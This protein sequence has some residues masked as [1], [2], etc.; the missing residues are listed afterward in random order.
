MVDLTSTVPKAPVLVLGASGQVGRALARRLGDACV[1]LTRREADLAHP[2]TLADILA[3]YGPAIIINAAAYTAVD[4]AEEEP[5]QAHT[6]NAIAPAEIAAYAFRHGIPFVHYSTDYVFPGKGTTAYQEDDATAPLNAYGKS[7]LAGE[8]AILAE[9]AKHQR[10]H[11]LIFRTCWV[12]D[13]LGKNFLNTMLRLGREKETLGV[14]SDQI[15]APTYAGDIAEYTLKALASA[16]KQPNFPSGIY[17]LCNQGETSWHGFATAIFDSARRHNIP[18]SVNVVNPIDSS[19]FPTLAT[20]PEN[21]RLSSAKLAQTFD[22]T[23][24]TWQDALNRCITA[25]QKQ[26][27]AF[28]EQIA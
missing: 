2:E 16:Q 5:E 1:A 26:D 15:G 27:A 18:L 13:E 28:M 20:R 10:A 14:V 17:H 7:K 11:Y 23:L 12:Y 9:A 3:S 19:A 24:P 4:R 6:I 25:K 21:S 22:L 8:Q